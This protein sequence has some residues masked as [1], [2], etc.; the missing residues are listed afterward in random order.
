MKLLF[1]YDN[2]ELKTVTDT[3]GRLIQSVPLSDHIHLLTTEEEKTEKN[4]CLYDVAVDVK[5]NIQ[6]GEDYIILVDQY[7]ACADEG[8]ERLQYNAGIA[9]I[10]FIR[11]LEVRSHIVLI[12]PFAGNEIELVK[13]NPANLIVTSKGISFAKNLHVFSKKS[14][15]DLEILAKDVFDDK[16]D[17]K[18]FILTEF[19]LPEDERHNWANWWGIDRLW[20]IN[21]IVEKEKYGLTERWNFKEYPGSLKNKVKE[22]KNRQ[23]LFLYGHQDKIIAN[24]LKEYNEEITKIAEIL[25]RYGAAMDSFIKQRETIKSLINA[26][27]F[28]IKRRESRISYIEFRLP[29]LNGLFSVFLEKKAEHIKRIVELYD[30]ISELESKLNEENGFN[31]H[32]RGLDNRIVSRENKLDELKNQFRQEEEKYLEGLSDEINNLET[33]VKKLQ[34]KILSLS[35]PAIREQ[36]QKKSPKILYIDDQADEGWSN[37]FQHIIYNKEENIQFEVIQ[38]NTDDTID[39]QYFTGSIVPKIENHNPDLILLDLRLNKESGV[40]FEVENLSGA[41]ILKEIRKQYPGIPVLMTTASNKSWSFEELQRIGCDAFW[42]KEGIDTGM[43]EADSIKNYLRFAELVNVLT[44]DD[45]K[46]LKDYYEKVKRLEEN[47][48]TRRHWW[49]QKNRYKKDE[50]KEV[51]NDFVYKILRDTPHIFKEYLRNKIMK[52]SDMAVWN[53]WFY[54]S[55]VIQTL[56]KIVEKLHYGGAEVSAKIMKYRED[57]CG[58]QLFLKRHNASHIETVETLKENDAKDYMK[59][60]LEYLNN[61]DYCPKPGLNILGKIKV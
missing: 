56:G 53:E 13:H 46:C 52:Q 6:D 4:R 25:G 32:I 61:K 2:A 44:G 37:I 54:A 26:K 9:L 24:R 39:S 34:S 47:G 1:I 36:L 41:I 30:Q 27:S 18:P 40:R 16:E 21:R 58:E 23:A 43:T 3:V 31:Q 33:E 57:F 20:N 49:Q 10:K 59:A 60:I 29:Y 19:S 5:K 45:Y 48:K 7:L 50:L 17:L 22:L 8:F 14:T 51:E 55:L 12:T 42:S 28:E 11:M 35:I 15:T 38:P